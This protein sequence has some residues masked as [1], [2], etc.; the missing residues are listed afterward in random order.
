[1]TKLGF[2]ILSH[3]QPKMLKRLVARL[4]YSFDHPRIVCHH[5]MHQFRLDVQEFSD[6]VQF[7]ADPVRTGW[8]NMSVLE[9]FL[10]GLRT[11]YS[12]NPPDWFTNLS[13]SDYP[14]RNGDE[15][16]GELGNSNYDAYMNHRLLSY[17]NIPNL[18][19]EHGVEQAFNRESWSKVGYDRYLARVITYPFINRKWKMCT[20]RFYLR[21]PSLAPAGPF[22]SAF[23]CYGG[24]TW[25]TG[26]SSCAEALI[27]DDAR[28]QALRK[29]YTG[30]EVP[31]ESYYQTVVC[32]IPGVKI[33]NDNKRFAEW[34]AGGSH[35]KFLG[36]EDLPKIAKSSAHFARKFNERS[37]AAL[38]ELDRKIGY[39]LASSSAH[40]GA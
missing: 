21:H 35:P 22:D 6:N 34:R 27:R 16:L 38:D 2:V 39:G 33:C 5:D 11:L 28:S 3:T 25:F 30:R 18:H 32:N 19:Q 40:S 1:M 37:E 10:L 9:A 26:R 12:R 4:N 15:I 13:T 14:V 8:G 20:R 31:D 7:V 36:L 17:E 29:H 24:D 23:R